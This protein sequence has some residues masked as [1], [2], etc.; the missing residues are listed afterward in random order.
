MSKQPPAPR[1]SPRDDTNRYAALVWRATDKNP[2]RLWTEHPTDALTI[3]LEYLKAGY[4]VRLTDG[5]VAWFRD[6]P[7]PTAN[8]YH[9]ALGSLRAEIDQAKAALAGD[10]GE[11]EAL[12]GLTDALDRL[13]E[14][15]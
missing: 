7:R 8:G 1:T 13:L 5:A 4:Q 15:A 2:K 11:H 10:A 6:L 9:D 14:R 3:A 12:A